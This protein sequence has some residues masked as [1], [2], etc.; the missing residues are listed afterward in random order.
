MKKLFFSFA[1]VLGVINF[2]AQPVYKDVASIFYSRCTS[3]HNQASHG[4]SYLNYSSTLPWVSSIQTD[5]LSNRM[6]PWTPD[7]NYTRFIH[8]NK[9]APQEKTAILNWISAGA[10]K[11]DTSLAPTPPAYSQYKL[12]GNPNLELQIPPFVSNAFTSDSYIC[13]SLPMGLNQDRI[14]RAYEIIAG[15]PKIVHHVIANID[16]SGTTTSDLSGTCYN[17]TGDFSIGGFAPGSPPTVFPGQAPLK[18]G[19]RI[20]AGSKLVLQIHYPAGTS[21]KPDS[22]KIRLYFYPIGVTGV[23]PVYVSTPLQNW[24]LNIPANSTRTFTAQYPSSGGLPLDISIFS[25]FPHSHKTATTIMNF[26]CTTTDTVPLI[27]INQWDFDQQGYYTFQKMVKV[28]TGHKLYSKHVYVNTNNYAVYAGTNTT[29]EM[30]FD[31]FQ[32]MTY[33]P[34]D[35]TIS[36]KDLL[37]ADSLFMNVTSVKEYTPVSNDLTTYAFPNPFEHSVR[38][39][40]DLNK[41]GKVSVDIYSVYGILVRTLQN[42][43]EMTGIH[44]VVWDGKNAGGASLP[45]GTYIY[46][47]KTDSKQCYGKLSLLSAKN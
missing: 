14:L 9:I 44:E 45:G 16:T 7:T 37:A 41:A 47:I 36:I 12:S 42:S 39:G 24:G 27:R 43:F 26:A 35:E 4:P 22:T 21:G 18:M 30:L 34:G 46:L 25:T 3:C 28:S 15:D 20:K 23:R 1:F 29:D 5:L 8:E 32:W 13:F 17:I 6:P 40:Y 10:Q 11:G 2:R 33:Q 19:I 31:S 38:I